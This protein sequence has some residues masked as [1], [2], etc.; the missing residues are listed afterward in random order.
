MREVEEKIPMDLKVK[1]NK[2][3]V[4]LVS[5]EHAGGRFNV[6]EEALRMGTLQGSDSS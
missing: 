6:T 2:R 3:K 5:L 1:E 4:F